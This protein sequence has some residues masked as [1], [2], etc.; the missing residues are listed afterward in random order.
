MTRLTNSNSNTERSRHF[1][2]S[3]WIILSIAAVSGICLLACF[4]PDGI[5][6]FRALNH[7]RVWHRHGNEDYTITIDGDAAFPRDLYFASVPRPMKLEVCNGRIVRINGLSCL[8]SSNPEN[9]DTNPVAS[10]FH[11]ARWCGHFCAVKFNPEY[12]FPRWIEYQNTDLNQHLVAYD[13]S[14]ISCPD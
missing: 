6:Y 12:G 8:D 11:E 7:E 5:S 13:Y 1:L 4:L 2:R 14:T 3:R 10:L 9:C